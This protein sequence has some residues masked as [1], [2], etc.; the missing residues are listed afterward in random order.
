MNFIPRMNTQ[1]L[2]NGNKKIIHDI[3]TT[4]PYYKR[5]RQLLLNYKLVN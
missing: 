2:V 5:I 4:K 1:E 3:Y